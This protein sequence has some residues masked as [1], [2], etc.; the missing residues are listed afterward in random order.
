[1]IARVAWSFSLLIIFSSCGVLAPVSSPTVDRSADQRRS[2]VADIARSYLGVP[3]QY[4][5]AGRQGLDCSG[6]VHNVFSQVGLPLPRTAAKQFRSGRS[7]SIGQSTKGDLIFFTQK[8]KIN[9]V[10]IVTRTSRSR[11]W[12]VHSTTSKG[13]IEEEV[14]ASPYW[15]TR[16]RGV[17]DVLGR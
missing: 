10:G 11:I 2:T 3:Y 13:V 7:Q 16:I 1:M 12:V 17:R 4:G 15:S 6:L 8:G 5:G 9:H 14:T